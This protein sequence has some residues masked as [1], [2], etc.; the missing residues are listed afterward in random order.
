MSVYDPSGRFGARTHCVDGQ[1]LTAGSD[2]I[3]L[4]FSA[5]ND[6]DRSTDYDIPDDSVL[7]IR[8]I[9]IKTQDAAGI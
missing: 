9:N 4:P 3:F 8:T 5:L 7:A 1:R 2:S 6:N